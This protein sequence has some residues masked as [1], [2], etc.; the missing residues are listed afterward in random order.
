MAWPCDRKWCPTPVLAP[1]EV[2]VV[3]VKYSV[4][5]QDG[6][7]TAIDDLQSGYHMVYGTQRIGIRWDQAAEECAKRGFELATVRNHVEQ[8]AVVEA[9]MK[10]MVSEVQQRPG[11][12][13]EFTSV[14][15]GA[16]RETFRPFWHWM[17]G[18]PVWEQNFTNWNAGGF[19][20]YSDAALFELPDDNL[21]HGDDK[22]AYLCMNAFTFQW[23]ECGVSENT[24]YAYACE[25]RSTSVE[26]SYRRILESPLI[27]SVSPNAG[28]PGTLLTLT[29]DRFVT[30]TD[31]F[32]FPNVTI[33]GEACDIVSSNM[34]TVVCSMPLTSSGVVPVRMSTS[35][36]AAGPGAL[37]LVTVEHEVLSVTPASG[38]VGGGQTVTVTGSNLPLQASDA[39][40]SMVVKP[41]NNSNSS[42]FV[43]PCTVLSS[44]YT[45]L[46]CVTGSP[47]ASGAVAGG[48]LSRYDTQ[49]GGL[50]RHSPMTGGEQHEASVLVGTML[51][52]DG[53]EIRVVSQSEYANF[54][55]A[56]RPGIYV[57]SK[58]S[59]VEHMVTT[60]DWLAS[61]WDSRLAAMFYDPFTRQVVSYCT[62]RNIYEDS[63]PCY[64]SMSTVE[65]VA[66]PTDLVDYIR[67]GTKDHL[68]FVQ[69]HHYLNSH[70]YSKDLIAALA[71]CGGSSILTNNMP[72][73]A[74]AID[75]RQFLSVGQCGA[76]LEYGHS[77][78]LD[79][80]KK[81]ESS[82]QSLEIQFD[83]FDHFSFEL[84]QAITSTGP[85]S[86][87]YDEDK[88]A[89]VEWISR[90]NG[91][92][93]G[94]TTV[95]LVGSGFVVNQTTV[96]LAGITC[97]L[98]RDQVGSYRGKNL[99]DWD[100]VD[101][102]GLGVDPTGTSLTCLTGVWDYSGDAFNREVDVSV[103]ANGLALTADTVRWSYANL[104]SSKTTWGGNDPPIEGDSVVI[105]Y[106]EFIVLDVSPPELVLLTI[107]GNLE[108]ARDVGDLALNCSYIVLHYGRLFVGTAE[109][110][111]VTYKATITLVGDRSSYELPVYG[112]KTIAVRTAELYLHGRPRLRSWTKLAETVEPGN[113]TL[114]LR[115]D[116]DW[117]AGDHIFVSSTDYQML[118]AEECYIK[119]VLSSDGRVIEVTRPLQYQHWG[120]GWTS[121]DGKHDMDNY[122]ASVGL[123]TRN[124]V[125]QGDHVHTKKE[126][127]GSQIVL[128]TESNTGDNPLVGQFSNV[129]V[130]QAGQG[131]KLGKYPIHFH[132]VGN[133][134]KSYVKNCS[135]HHSF[136]RGITIH[137]VDNLLVEH[138]VLFDTRGH[139]IFT[140][141]GTERFNTIRYNLVSVVRPIWSLLL[142]DQSPACFW[143]V[144][145]TNDIYGNVAAGS[146]H[147]GFW[148]RALPEP[149]GISG[150]MARDAGQLRCPNWSEL[151]YVADNVAHSTGR[152]GLKVSNFFPVKGGYYCPQEAEPAPAT[153]HNFTSF[154]NRHMGIWGEFL[155]DVSFDTLRLAD[156]VKSGI[157]F[158]FI[159]G[160]DA[161]YATTVI[162]G[163]LFVGRMLDEIDT[164]ESPKCAE[165]RNCQGPT[166]TGNE[167]NGYFYPS[168]FD[169]GNGWTHGINLPGIGSNVIVRGA[170]FVNYQAAIY[171]CSWCVAHRGG[172]EMEFWNTTFSNVEHIAHFKHGMGGILVD[173]DGSLGTGS[174]GGAIVPHTGQWR[175]NSDCAMDPS[176]RFARC[177]GVVRRVNVGIE[178][179]TS[180]WWDTNIKKHYPLLIAVDVTDE[181]L[182]ST[183]DKWNRYKDETR[184][185]CLS[186][187]CGFEHYATP[188][189]PEACFE[190][191]PKNRYSF[192]AQVGRR[193]LVT[194]VDQN[195]IRTTA[196]VEISVTKMRP[197]EAIVL[198]FTHRP[199]LYERLPMRASVAQSSYELWGE[200]DARFGAW[201]PPPNVPTYA[202]PY[203]DHT[204]DRHLDPCSANTV[205]T[206][207]YQDSCN[208]GAFGSTGGFEA[209]QLTMD[210]SVRS[211]AQG[212]DANLTLA[213]E[214]RTATGGL[215]HPFNGNV[216]WN[217][218]FVASAAADPYMY[219]AWCMFLQSTPTT[220]GDVA[221]R[222]RD[223]ASR[224]HDAGD[225]RQRFKFGYNW[226]AEWNDEDRIGNEDLWTTALDE[227]STEPVHRQALMLTLA[228]NPIY[229]LDACGATI[230]SAD[231]TFTTG[232]IPV[233]N[234]CDEERRSQRVGFMSYF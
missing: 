168:I 197:D 232:A 186:D 226:Q 149:D 42:E 72:V 99:C 108:F 133:V 182:D 146:S 185:S 193:Y 199:P 139:T 62:V 233:A 10:R 118:Q 60:S 171:G 124:V 154:K 216:Q 152:H 39:S 155:V 86:F 30:E 220:S 121:T 37:P 49:S 122:R 43:I 126:Q 85:T 15:L 100:G 137:G 11:T 158:K 213:A 218:A 6:R 229:C 113:T 26:E 145:P 208:K 61:G 69:T 79:L 36:G 56:F 102:S 7:S 101:C 162:K 109:D 5:V 95:Q 205:I 23:H 92:T 167:V 110:P 75:T 170:A 184:V 116:T 179:W 77:A 31:G 227:G 128:S 215:L 88:T 190:Q 231:C 222:L 214:G 93:A 136:N 140:E 224:S 203:A 78:A 174:V 32:A 17:N 135:V 90:K 142:V 151:G 45:S 176:G 81:H 38:S 221:L 22:V 24:V 74:G 76:G 219:R 53:D 94:G 104:W 150:G 166:P 58:E 169:M 120:A 51:G 52:M 63:N 98:G 40:V 132:M 143:I 28:L 159:N 234:V 34:S 163:A 194:W 54:G 46:T 41:V 4:F 84:P 47:V 13:A 83:P 35:L 9:V 48:T 107:Q 148:F 64:R 18:S 67:G 134:S 66:A 8:T 111:F 195:F 160:R 165:Q 183:W 27:T 200:L 44:S 173:G 119:A 19:N 175:T 96:K 144:N 87:V 147:Y 209:P 131:L 206:Q 187:N 25:E 188:L 82:W 71:S 189:G 207:A 217:G 65:G 80:E 73:G 112:A 12:G 212:L 16:R 130:R 50:G 55:D 201:S 68:L 105:T 97:A 156:H 57:S 21:W 181:E 198:Q 115:E 129:E 141:D 164:P 106:G 127:F 223:C 157:E 70:E 180:P 196:D 125:I 191:A 2:K 20:G 117:E 178:Q 204:G 192:L 91:T 211:L 29:G 14:W 89:F 202:E 33:G 123:L 210:P 3:N 230:A 103:G 1:V 114:V 153:F 225:G 172:Y 59:G 177:A 138:N 228:S 161:K